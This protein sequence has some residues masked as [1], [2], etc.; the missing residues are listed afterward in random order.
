MKFD[1][2]F[3][4]RNGT[5]V[6]GLKYQVMII[7]GKNTKRHLVS[8]ASIN[9]KGTGAT[10]VGEELLAIEV[11]GFPSAYLDWTEIWRFS[12][13]RR[14]ERDI[15]RIITVEIPSILVNTKT[16]PK[17]EMSGSYERKKKI[18]D[19]KLDKTVY[20]YPSVVKHTVVSGDSLES[21]ARLHRTTVSEIRRK[22]KISG[23]LIKIGTQLIIKDDLDARREVLKAQ[24]VYRNY[25]KEN[26]EVSKNNSKVVIEIKNDQKGTQL[27]YVNISGAIAAVVGVGGSLQVGAARTPKGQWGIFVTPGVSGV[28]GTPSISIEGGYL[29]S[30]AKSLEDLAGFGYSMNV[31]TYALVGAST[32]VGAGLS[33]KID[34]DGISID[35]T[36]QMGLEAGIGMGANIQHNLSYTF[37]IPLT[38]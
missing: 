9:G 18:L 12:Y 13:G 21:I 27:I 38:K 36:K 17:Q 14:M 2:R 31:N 37:V 22:N 6:N 5:R 24:K 16:F 20:L 35:T 29:I 28:Q 8:S 3:I 19:N 34:E 4:D 1:L 30:E 7:T 25:I 26:F 32:V 10:I 15:H 33:S 23:S 11:K